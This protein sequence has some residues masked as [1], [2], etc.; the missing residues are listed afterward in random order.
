MT[1]AQAFAILLC[2]AGP[3]AL[4]AAAAAPVRP[5]RDAAL[6]AAA[7][8]AAGGLLA[9]FPPAPTAAPALALAAAVI[10]L[11]G[12][13]ARLFWTGPLAALAVFGGWS[14]VWA[15]TGLGP[16]A[17][18]LSAVAAAAPPLAAA[19]LGPRLA[20][21]ARSGRK[22]P[23]SLALLCVALSA[24]ALFALW[25]AAGPGTGLLAA[26]W[27]V[28]A[29]AFAFAGA[30]ARRWAV[31]AGFGLLAIGMALGPLAIPVANFR[32]GPD[33]RAPLTAYGFRLFDQRVLDG[34]ISEGRIVWVTVQG[35]LC[36]ACAGNAATLL[37]AQ[38]MLD[39]AGVTVMTLRRDDQPDATA[40]ML[41]R[42]N[43]LNPP[44]DVAFGPGAPA[45]RAAPA[46]LRPP[47]LRRT[48]AAAAG[49]PPESP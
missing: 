32:T 47:A 1:A 44:L 37:E 4:A 33:L 15:P 18:G 43:H 28:A 31:R 30:W 27:A 22:L 2:S 25:Q 10:A 19:L 5:W 6:R 40:A 42:F 17:I 48:L 46:A 3:L 20:A 34:L 12:A 36:P 7:A 45:G 16:V 35:P 23:H 13:P 8:A 38:A 24:A 9:A 41:A 21:M 11:T 29:A 39:A 26:G 49:G 14:V